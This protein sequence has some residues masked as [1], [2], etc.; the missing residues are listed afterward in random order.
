MTMIS[1]LSAS[2]NVTTNAAIG[3]DINKEQSWS[4]IL[5]KCL[6]TPITIQTHPNVT[7]DLTRSHIYTV[8][9][10]EDLGGVKTQVTSYLLLLLSLFPYS[11]S[12]SFSH[13]RRG[14]M[15]QIVHLNVRDSSLIV[16]Q[17]NPT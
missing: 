14:A 7:G 12:T 17:I 3:G 16:V 13:T 6:T 10:A 5:I 15:G 4:S 2:Y 1:G 11:S 8:L 9:K